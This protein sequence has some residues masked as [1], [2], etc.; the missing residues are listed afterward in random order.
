MTFP[1]E[2]GIGASAVVAP[3]PNLSTIMELCKHFPAPLLCKVKGCEL[4]TAIFIQ[5]C[6]FHRT[7]EV[8][9]RRARPP[10]PSLGMA[11]MWHMRLKRQSSDGTLSLLGCE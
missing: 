1:T 7:K 8:H 10:A 9:P 2:G 5:W 3:L 4:F 11:H 6:C